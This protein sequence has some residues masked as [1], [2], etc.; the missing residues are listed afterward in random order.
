MIRT[1]VRVAVLGTFI[2]R[3]A[4]QIAAR[5]GVQSWASW[6]HV[7]LTPAPVMVTS[8]KWSAL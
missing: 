3:L 4:E 7:E 1:D 6:E 2:C 5:Q 8:R